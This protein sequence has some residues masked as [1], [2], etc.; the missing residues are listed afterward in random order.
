MR[1]D[2]GDCRG[3]RAAAERLQRERT[4]GAPRLADVLAVE[5][6]P[7]LLEPAEDHPRGLDEA[8]AGFVHVDAKALELDAPEPAADAE[9]QAAPER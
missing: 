9:D 7:A 8:P 6:A 5:L 4:D 1:A 2:S 3:V